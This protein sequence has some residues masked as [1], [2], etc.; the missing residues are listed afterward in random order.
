MRALASPTWPTVTNH[1]A[2]LYRAILNQARTEHRDRQRRWSKGLRAAA[3]ERTEPPEYR[4]EVLGAVRSLSLRQRAVIV[5][6]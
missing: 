2:Y 1:R 5:L 6:T 3:T 4:P